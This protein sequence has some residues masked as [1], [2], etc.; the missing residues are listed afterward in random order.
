MLYFSVVLVLSKK[1]ILKTISESKIVH[2]INEIVN[3]QH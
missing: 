1:K 2:K 3:T